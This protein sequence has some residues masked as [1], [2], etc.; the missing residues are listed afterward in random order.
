MVICS[1]TEKPPLELGREPVAFVHHPKNFPK[2]ERA[3]KTISAISL[4]LLDR[5]RRWE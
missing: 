3:G 2:R 1:S 4:E 5:W